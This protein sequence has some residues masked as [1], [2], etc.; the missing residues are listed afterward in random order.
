MQLNE[1][2]KKERVSVPKFAK[3]L[4]VHHNTVY[5]WLKRERDPSRENA[6][7]VRDATKGEVTLDEMLHIKEP[8]KKCPACGRKLYN[9][10][11]IHLEDNNELV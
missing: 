7:A 8:R 10:N 1:Y 11:I 9:K 3:R 2:L 5:L 4:G 6:I